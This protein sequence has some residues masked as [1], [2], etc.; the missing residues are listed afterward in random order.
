LITS[1]QENLIKEELNDLLEQEDLKWR[2]RAKE[3]WLKS[4]DRNSRYFHACTNQKHRRSRV[5]TIRDKEGRLC[6]TKE[7]IKGA[8]VDYFNELFKGGESLNVDN[9]IAGLD[10]RVSTTMNAKLLVEFTVD[11]IS[12]ALQ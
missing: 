1:S 7:E 11:E 4:G 9:F 6:S 3:D 12:L 10:N 5:S 2:Q 8:F